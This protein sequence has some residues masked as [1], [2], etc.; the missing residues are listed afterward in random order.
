MTLVHRPADP[1]LLRLIE[2]HP[3]A[4]LTDGESPVGTLRF[5]SDG[6]ERVVRTGDAQC[7]AFGLVELADNN[8]MVCADVFSVPGP[9]ATLALIAIGP[10]VRAGLVLDDP[11]LQFAG[12][13]EEDVLP[14]LAGLGWNGGAAVSFGEEDL[15][16]VAA[17]NALV[18]IATPEDPRAV[19][20][21]FDEAYGGS[22]YVRRHAGDEWD[23]SLVAGTPHAL[24]TLHTTSDEPRSLLTVR[25]MADR[26]GKCGACQWVHAM[27]VMCGFEE[28]AGIPG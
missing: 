26:D 28:C 27:N 15:G 11:A 17:V 13:S 18:E 6:W 4:R 10:L 7:E 5:V 14:F 2:A 9:A 23:T 1:A 3:G 16:T 8:P 12:L 25:A 20:A 22:F 21:L 24:Y 19:D